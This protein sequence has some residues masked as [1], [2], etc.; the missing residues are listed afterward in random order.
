MGIR[1]R[2]AETID[3]SRKFE[4]LSEANSPFA[5]GGSSDIDPDP[6]FWRRLTGDANRSLAPVDQARSFEIAY[7]LWKTNPLA[8]Q[9]IELTTSY[10]IGEGVRFRA[11]DSRVQEVLDRFTTD[12]LNR[13]NKKIKNRVR[14][15]GVFGEQ[16]R[17]AAVS[18]LNGKIRLGTL[19]P[20]T[21]TD[22]VTDPN[23]AEVVTHVVVGQGTDK[24]TLEAVR[25]DTETER[26]VG[27][28]I[29][30]RLNVPDNARRGTSDLLASA[31]WLDGLD[32]FLIGALDRVTLQNMFAFDVEIEG[33][34]QDEIE[35]YLNR[36]PPMRPGMVRAHNDRTKWSVLSPKIDSDEMPEFGK[37]ILRYVG[38]SQGFPPHWLGEEGSSNRATAQEMGTPVVKGL[39]A[40]QFDIK[41]LVEEDG[42]FVVDHA[43]HAGQLDGVTDFSFDVILPTIWGVDTDKIAGA[44]TKIAQAG[45]VA[46][47]NGWATNDEMAEVFR[48]TLGQLGVDLPDILESTG[49]RIPES[50]EEYNRIVS[51][52]LD[53]AGAS[54]SSDAA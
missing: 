28:V 13:Y 20:S 1:Q 9:L 35:D 22:L 30:W 10:V 43:F 34:D 54:L 38:T 2:I 4:R 24:R 14:F 39:K 46:V 42:M 5:S 41:C 52:Y 45:T 44:L 15:L 31:D 26:Y 36:L 40:R 19:D 53:Q 17:M 23:N 32:Q 33:A 25:F 48:F 29:V 50:V 8:R 11:R 51:T 6:R 21:V 7:Y 18:P 16:Y 3:P 49:E 47:Q 37:M 12:P 27:E